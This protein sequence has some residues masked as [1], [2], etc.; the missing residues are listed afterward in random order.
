MTEKD[1]TLRLD[2][3]SKSLSE[4]VN[5]RDAIKQSKAMFFYL[6]HL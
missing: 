5:K 6:S 4:K 1:E 2:F 3:Q